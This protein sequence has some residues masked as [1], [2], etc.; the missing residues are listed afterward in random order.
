MGAAG[1]IL[2]YSITDRKTFHSLENWI[3]QINDTQPENIA[4]IIVGNKCDCSDSDRQVSK[5]EGQALAAK[6][7]VKFLESSAKDNFNIP[8][9]FNSLGN[10]VKVKL[11]DTSSKAKDSNLKIQSKD[12]STIKGEKKSCC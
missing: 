2:V 12:V 3:K 4:K 10:D 7:G 5:E 8:E 11:T 6:Y 1:V 9:I